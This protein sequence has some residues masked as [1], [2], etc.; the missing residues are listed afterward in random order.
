MIS[1]VPWVSCDFPLNPSI[2]SPWSP[3]ES[4]GGLRGLG[5][6]HSLRHLGAAQGFD[7]PVAPV[8]TTGGQG[9]ARGHRGG[10]VR[11][12]RRRNPRNK[13]NTLDFF[14]GRCH[15]FL[16]INV[17]EV[18]LTIG[19]GFIVVFTTSLVIMHREPKETQ[20]QKWS[21][22]WQHSSSR[23]SKCKNNREWLEFT[24]LR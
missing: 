15:W 11:R 13:L 8:A 23:G 12:F 24:Q 19:M 22:A 21:S 3:L 16:F 1:W 7:V 2:W 20:A 5:L 17:D 4:L 14:N 6:F 9:E 18:K 10:I